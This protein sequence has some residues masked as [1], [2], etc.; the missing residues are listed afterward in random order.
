ME[1]SS[2][3]F[4]KTAFEL[5][6]QP[7]QVVLLKTYQNFKAQTSKNIYVAKKQKA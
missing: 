7:T 6:D 3:F 1:F 4:N 5:M 2:Y